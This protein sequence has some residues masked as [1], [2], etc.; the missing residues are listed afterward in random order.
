MYEEIKGLQNVELQIL[1]ELKRVCEKNNL[2]YSLAQGSLLGAVRHGG[3]IPWDDDIDVMMNYRDYVALK[4][5]CARDLGK[6]FFLQTVENEPESGLTFYKLRLSTTT[7]ILDKTVNKDINQGINIDIY[8]VYNV[9]DNKF[10][11]VI[12]IIMMAV[13][14]LFCEQHVPQNHGIFMAICSRMILFVFRGKQ[15]EKIKDF[16]HNY[17]AR[18]EGK[19]TKYKALLCGNLSCYRTIS[20]ASCFDN[21]I[22]KRFVDEYFPVIAEYDMFLRRVYGD[23]MKLPPEEEQGLKLDHIVK[24]DTETSYQEYKGKLYCIPESINIGD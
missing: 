5:A 9:A 17:M 13:Y 4:E 12:Q 18:Y 2:M 15:R 1:K 14:F 3:F 24:F 16:C 23:Y 6:D 21:T 8:P 22:P 19:R 7:Y 10:M 11:R 20:P